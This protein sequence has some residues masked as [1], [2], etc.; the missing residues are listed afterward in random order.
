MQKWAKDKIQYWMNSSDL[1]SWI[2][3]SIVVNGAPA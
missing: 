2:L 3:A 1:S